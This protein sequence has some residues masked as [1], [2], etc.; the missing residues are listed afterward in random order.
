MALGVLQV[1]ARANVVGLAPGVDCV[2]PLRRQL[3]E[4][5]LALPKCGIE[6]WK[7]LE[8]I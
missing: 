3:E 4:E 6:K 2:V 7:S 1:L 5:T 8:S